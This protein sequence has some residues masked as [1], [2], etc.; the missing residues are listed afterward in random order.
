MIILYSYN[1]YAKVPKGGGV[2]GWG[3]F[4]RMIL[5]VSMKQVCVF[6]Y[7]N[8]VLSRKENEVSST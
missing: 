4:F 2:G 8:D 7:L 5:T 3:H 6:H 1:K